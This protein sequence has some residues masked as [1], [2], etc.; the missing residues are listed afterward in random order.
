MATVYAGVDVS[1]LKL[2]VFLDGELREVSNEP[3]ECRKLVKEMAKNKD[4]V[5]VV[6]ATGGYERT[7]TDAAHAVGLPVCVV[8]PRRVRS[9][10]V[11][12]GKA[13]K[14]DRM[15]AVLLADFGMAMNPRPTPKPEDL[16]ETLR[17]FVDLR[18]QL[19][20]DRVRIRNR[21]ESIRD[22]D[23][24]KIAEKQFRQTEEAIKKT[25]AKIEEVRGQDAEIKRT[26]EVLEAAHGVGK[27]VSAILVSHLPELGKVN[28][29]E[30]ASLAGLAPFDHESGQ[31]KGKRTI[32]GGREVVRRA[33]Y[34]AATV[35]AVQGRDKV[36]AKA[37]ED[38]V[39]KGKPK[40]VAII[41]CARKLL[42]HLNGLVKAALEAAPSPAMAPVN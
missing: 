24:R 32:Y 26:S 30:V 4:L 21:L 38:M 41:A 15:D 6:E 22:K 18:A 13:A 10:A 12:Q 9:F 8:Q 2:D 14:N 37:Y 1:K 39:V 31:W 28:R 35:A 40:K 36:L 20:E 3:K 19:V 42:V 17:E 5:V 34:I 29:Q 23:A 16:R 11:A 7:L 25:E 33:V 27:Q